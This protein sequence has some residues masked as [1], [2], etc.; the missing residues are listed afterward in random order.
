MAPMKAK[1]ILQVVAF[2]ALSAAGAWATS[3]L[4][5]SKSNINRQFPRAAV[6]TASSDINGAR[7]QLVYTTPADS[8]FLLTQVCVGAAAGGVLVQAGGASIVLVPSG[9]CQTFS[10]G[11][12][13]P[14]GQ[15]VTCTTFA[16]EAN[17]FCSIT[18]LLGPAAR[19]PTVTPARP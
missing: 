13:L 7:A 4:N 6:V 17:T 12:I 1:A 2:L 15:P 10:P 18:G 8:D 11:A 16:E 9:Q 3:N 14:P 19:T 5:L